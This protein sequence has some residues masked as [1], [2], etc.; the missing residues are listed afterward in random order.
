MTQSRRVAERYCVVESRRDT[1]R[2]ANA[3]LCFPDLPCPSF[4]CSS[5]ADCALARHTG[6][7]DVDI[8]A[9]RETRRLEEHEDT[10]GIPC[11]A[12]IREF[13][14][15]VFV[16]AFLA[17]GDLCAFA[18]LRRDRGPYGLTG[19]P[20]SSHAPASTQ[21]RGLRHG[22]YARDRRSSTR[23]RFSSAFESPQQELCVFAPLRRNFQEDIPSLRRCVVAVRHAKNSQCVAA[24][25]TVNGIMIRCGFGL[26]ST[27]S[28]LSTSN[29][30]PI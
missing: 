21:D 11:R 2:I 5:A 28:K 24:G 23:Q 27:V 17:D 22:T 29:A 6:G 18:A 12:C 10:M 19:H 30:L 13:A 16:F 7:R 25:R 14:C 3:C 8:N 26:L 4:Q 9:A 15:V 20:S 1:Q